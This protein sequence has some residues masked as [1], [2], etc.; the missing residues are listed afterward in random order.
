MSN[1]IFFSALKKIIQRNTYLHIL[2]NKLFCNFLNKTQFYA[3]GVLQ[4]L[5]ATTNHMR[6]ALMKLNNALYEGEYRRQQRFTALKNQL[7]LLTL[8]S[9]FARSF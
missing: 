8:S 6:S 9:A 5:V 1:K 7:P 4:T 2:N 3:Y